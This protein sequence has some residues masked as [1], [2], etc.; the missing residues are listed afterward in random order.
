MQRLNAHTWNKR[1]NG[2][3]NASRIAHQPCACV[4]F[5]TACWRCGPL[6]M[7]ASYYATPWNKNKKANLRSFWLG[8][9]FLL[10]LLLI[11]LSLSASDRCR[12]GFPRHPPQGQQ[13]PARLALSQQSLSKGDRQQPLTTSYLFLAS[14]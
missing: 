1:G 2:G 11:S 9:F 6:P 4:S 3:S 14:A 12:L 8:A 7:H 5:V 10:Y 13:L